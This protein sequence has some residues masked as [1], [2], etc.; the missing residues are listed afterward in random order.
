[1]AH[2]RGATVRA[3][4]A[5][6][7]HGDVCERGLRSLPGRQDR[8]RAPGRDV[9]RAPLAH[10]SLDDPPPPTPPAAAAHGEADPVLLPE[11]Y[12]DHDVGTLLYAGSYECGYGGGRG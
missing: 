3:G 9:A 11:E 2:G 4:R 6:A 7:H 12:L 8:H 1:M 5:A 10:R